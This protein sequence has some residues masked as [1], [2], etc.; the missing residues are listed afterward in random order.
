MRAFGAFR[1]DIHEITDLGGDDILAVTTALG[2]PVGLA[3]ADTQFLN[4]CLIVT[5]RDGKV[6]GIRS[7]LE[8]ARALEAA[9][10]SE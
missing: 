3:G 1:F 10:L 8:K 6:V 4:W 5:L 7:F 9:G 2:R